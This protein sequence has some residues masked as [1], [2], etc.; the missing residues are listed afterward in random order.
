MWCARDRG[1][2]K[3]FLNAAN[4]L[5]QRAP[6]GSSFGER[7]GAAGSAPIGVPGSAPGSGSVGATVAAGAADAAGP[8][9][10]AGAAG[11]GPSERG[12]GAGGAPPVSIQPLRPSENSTRIVLN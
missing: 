4:D 10:A 7:P 6:F 12:G 11:A 8:A 3:S 2:A 5:A 9:G 1:V